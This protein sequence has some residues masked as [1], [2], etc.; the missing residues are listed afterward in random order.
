MS[1][2]RFQVQVEIERMINCLD[3][4]QLGQQKGYFKGEI[5]KI[6]ISENQLLALSTAAQ[7]DASG[8]FFKAL[9]SIVEAME[10]LT[11]G[12]HSWAVIKLYYS[13]F[14]LLRCKMYALGHVFFK[15]AGT[16]Y[17][18]EL[19]K[20]ATPIER[21]RGKFAGSDIR[22]DHKTI[23]ATY[24]N[25]LG[26]QDI[27]LT[28]KI[29]ADSVFEWMMSA[30]EDVHYRDPTFSEPLP[31]IFYEELF[32]EAGLITWMSN[33]LNDPQVIYC[34]LAEHCCLA[35]PLVLARATLAEY[36]TRFADPP[37]SAAQ[38]QHLQSKL[39]GIFQT[40]TDFHA[41]INSATMASGSAAVA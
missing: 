18:V 20:N 22:G 7:V 19:S 41:L 33:Y 23:L 40:T 39:A 27:L 24:I 36:F 37:L 12:G 31:G 15:C 29:G 25:H 8:T 4:S 10:G 35:T 28:N 2:N 34:F 21:S 30:R 32:S 38:G 16:I 26:T 3:P 6:S 17:S 11:R 13:T 9:L 5:A 14:Y 1:S